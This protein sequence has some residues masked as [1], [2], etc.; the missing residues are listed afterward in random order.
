MD[1]STAGSGAATAGAGDG[2]GGGE[3]RSTAGQ[4]GVD[5]PEE[6]GGRKRGP[7]PLAGKYVVLAAPPVTEEPQEGDSERREPRAGAFT[8]VSGPID[9]DGQSEAKRAAIEANEKLQEA[10]QGDGVFLA[11]V[12]AASWQPTLVRAEQPPP[13]IKG[14]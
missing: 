1:G 11:A 8:Q 10:V 13:I 5:I 9:A 3:E 2:N 7:H 4:P 6:G 12:P 14:L